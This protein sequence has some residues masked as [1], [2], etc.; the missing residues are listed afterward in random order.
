LS[1]CY[2]IKT[3]LPSDELSKEAAHTCYKSLSQIE[4]AFRRS[5]TIELEMRPVHVRLE[6][7]TRG[8]FLVV[9]LAYLLMEELG[10]RWAKL[11]KTISEGLSGLNTYCLIEAGEGIVLFPT[12][13][14]SVSELFQAAGLKWPPVIKGHQ[15]PTAATKTKL[16][17]HFPKRLK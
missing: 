1:G 4:A 7:S 11:D 16:P 8:H 2:V 6:S 17:K 5:K 9:M 13:R 12:P 15:K 14:A 3:N 10:R